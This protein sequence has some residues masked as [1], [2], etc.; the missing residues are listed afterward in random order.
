MDRG[1]VNRFWIKLAVVGVTAYLGAMARTVLTVLGIL[2]ALWLVFGL[3]IPALFATL[4]FLFIIGII[5]LVV[6][7]AVTVVGKLSR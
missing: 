1:Y 7:V 5:A 6:V 2:L 4:K 3:V